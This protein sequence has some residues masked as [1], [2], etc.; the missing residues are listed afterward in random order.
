MIDS[1]PLM[2]LA[3]FTDWSWWVYWL[4]VGTAGI[5]LFVVPLM[6]RYR[7]TDY[8]DLPWWTRPWSNP[9]DWFGQQNHFQSSLPRWWVAAHG[10]EF[11][12]WYKY[13][14]IRNPAN[15]M[16]SFELLDL[17]I[18]PHEV[19][20]RT[21]LYYTRYEPN[22]LRNIG[23]RNAGYL[24]WQGW[25]AGI[26]YI[27]IWSNSKHLVIKLGW[28]VEPRDAIDPGTGIGITDASFASKVLPYRQG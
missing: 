17:D 11:K 7:E 18:R 21:P 24:A 13:H 5:G 16:R 2:M 20:F 19:K 4:P 10:I 22:A 25:K 14:A 6:W 28:R 1:F 8:E 27:H 23:K 3:P 26:K 9:E 12:S 15:G